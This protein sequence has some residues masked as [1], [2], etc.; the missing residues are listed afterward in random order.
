MALFSTAHAEIKKAPAPSGLS[1]KSKID[2]AKIFDGKLTDAEGKAVSAENLKKA[3]YV[4]VYFSAHWCPPCRAF[5]PKLVS[6]VE[7]NRKDG[8]FEVVFVSSDQNKEKMHEYMKGAKMNW[9]GVHNQELQSP[10]IGKGINGIPHLRVFDNAG[11]IVI[12]SVK[13][14]QYVG[15]NYVLDELKKKLQ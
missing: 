12:D 9:G 13:D 5:T 11:E 4:A 8:N 3:K 2:L 7:E 1:A 15:P 10:E 14:G 6:F